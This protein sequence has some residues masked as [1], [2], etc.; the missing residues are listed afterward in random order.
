MRVEGC[1]LTVKGVRLRVWG[2]SSDICFT[3]A[4]RNYGS[5]FRVQGSGFRVQGSRCRVQGAGCRVQG[6]GRYAATK[7]RPMA[8]RN[9]VRYSGG[10]ITVGPACPRQV[11]S[12]QFRAVGM[13][14]TWVDGTCLF[15]QSVFAGR[16]TDVVDISALPGVWKG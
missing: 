16:D 7:L 2:I 6:A 4:F 15:H 10:A 11:V 8:S 14:H 12:P 9:R 1:E 5:G 13:C 3:M